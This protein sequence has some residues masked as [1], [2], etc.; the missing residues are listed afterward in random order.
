MS[1]G[2]GQPSKHCR[3]ACLLASSSPVGEH[4]PDHALESHSGSPL[5]EGA[6]LGVGGG[7][8]VKLLEHNKLVSVKVTGDEHALASH[9]GDVVAA[10]ELLGNDGAKS[11]GQMVLRVN[12]DV[13]L[14]RFSHF[15][16]FD[17]C[18]FDLRL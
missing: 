18:K 10:E 4:T 11:T 12:N 14:P 5:V 6:V 7:S 8:L 16:C 17:I 2:G 13:S 3:R 15:R 9:N 1:K